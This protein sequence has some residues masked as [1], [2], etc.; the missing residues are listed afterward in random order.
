M[1]YE[2]HDELN[3]AKKNSSLKIR[4][5]NDHL[6]HIE[7]IK[8]SANQKT[9]VELSTKY[10]INDASCLLK[11]SEFNICTSLLQ[12]PMHMF[13]EG[14]CHLELKALLN[15]TIEKEILN[16]NSLNKKIK[17]FNYFFTDKNDTPNTI[18]S[19]NFK[20]STFTQTSSQMK[21]LFQNLP[22]IIGNLYNFDD[23][24][25]LNFLR[26]LKIINLCLSFGYDLHSI[27]KLNDLIE[28]YINNFISLYPHIN[29]TPKFHFMRHL[30]SQI[31]N[32]G[33]PR[34]HSSFR[35]E[36]K[37]GQL[38]NFKF[39]CFKNITKSISY[40]QELWMLSKKLD[41]S[42]NDKESY[43]EKEIEFKN[44]VRLE[45]NEEILLRNEYK[46]K[47][48]ILYSCDE[49]K[50][51]GFLYKVNSIL[52]IKEKPDGKIDLFGRITKI[53]VEDSEIK[54]IVNVFGI[55]TIIRCENLLILENTNM[56][57]F[58]KLNELKHKN[59]MVYFHENDMIK[60]Q[61]RYYYR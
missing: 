24:N 4:N 32:Y 8:N 43:F 36:A 12:D 53:V 45:Y 16:I 60:V 19:F 39:K 29:I 23:E 50:V 6:L 48:T 2:I 5:L 35:F 9:S 20:N 14:I 44:A 61:V 56:T 25:W 49:A 41:I 58:I 52:I 13:F 33:P 15:Y 46:N 37:N 42:F 26:L 55:A 21:V 27:K 7:E 31:L 18:D 57:K 40:R 51:N 38:K 10:G 28:T 1:C 54:F 59:P 17:E 30:P 11:L 22:V 47:N 34:F 3:V